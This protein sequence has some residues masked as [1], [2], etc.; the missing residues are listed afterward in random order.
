MTDTVTRI[1]LIAYFAEKSQSNWIGRTALIKLC[2]LLQTLR[3]VSLGYNFTLYSYGPFDAAVLQDLGN[4]VALGFVREELTLHGLG[5]GYRIHNR[6]PLQDVQRWSGS[7]LQNHREDIHWVIEEFGNLSASRLE[8]LSTIVYADRE[9]DR[10]RESL[11]PE[12]LAARVREVKPRFSE[13]Q[14]LQ[15]VKSLKQKAL[16]KSM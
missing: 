11:T 12:R 13:P 2:Y 5:Y 10:S 9:A 1:A 6:L 16:L 14:I 15:E 7:F 3:H 4:A 8:L